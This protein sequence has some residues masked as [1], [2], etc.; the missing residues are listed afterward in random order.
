[1]SDA[2]VAQLAACCPLLAVLSVRGCVRVTDA[3]VIKL[4]QVPAR[5]SPRRRLCASRIGLG[6]KR[7]GGGPG[8]DAETS[9]RAPLLARVSLSVPLLRPLSESVYATV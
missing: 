8:R 2:A 1:M 4:A 5:A 3:A 7:H 9:L 6:A